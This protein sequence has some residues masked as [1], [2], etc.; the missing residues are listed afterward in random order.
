MKGGTIFW[1]AVALLSIAAIALIVF[2]PARVTGTS[3]KSLAY[4]L[5]RANDAGQTGRCK[6]DDD[7]WRCTVFTS[8][9]TDGSGVPSV[10]SVD[11]DGWGCWSA[12]GMRKGGDPPLTLD[13]C[14][15]IADLIRSA[16]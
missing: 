12:E 14:I 5:R 8:G 11:V 9:G 10:Y 13:G 7:R 16:D 15:T 2:R 6:G 4:S 1:L 3:E